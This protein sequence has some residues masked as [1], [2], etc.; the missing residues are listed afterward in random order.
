VAF[1]PARDGRP[2]ASRGH[3]AAQQGT[4]RSD[5]RTTNVGQSQMGNKFYDD[6]FACGNCNWGDCAYTCTGCLSTDQALVPL[7]LAAAQQCICAAGGCFP[8][9]LRSASPPPAGAAL[10]GPSLSVAGPAM[11]GDDAECAVACQVAL[12]AGALASRLSRWR[13]SASRQ[14][15]ARFRCIRWSVS[16][17]ALK[18]RAGICRA[19]MSGPLCGVLYAV[20]WAFSVGF[21]MAVASDPF[22][23]ALADPTLTMISQGLQV[24][25]CITGCIMRN[26]FRSE[27]DIDGNIVEDFLC[28]FDQPCLAQRP[29][30]HIIVYQLAS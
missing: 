30:P 12:H 2:V 19:G 10:L 16:Y 29:R 5:I 17:A 7:Q 23:P 3:A 8:R 14:L 18:L 4:G 28:A 1:L 11:R 22:N 24:T 9:T 15:L 21:N 26:K 20:P 27:N 6:T 13:Q 25:L